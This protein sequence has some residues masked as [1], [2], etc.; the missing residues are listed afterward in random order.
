MVYTLEELKEKVIPI[1]EKH[2]LSKVYLFGSYAR[3]EADKDSDVDL[4]VDQEGGDYFSVYCDYLD[5][6]GE[7]VD[8]LPLSTLLNPNTNIGH[9]VKQNFLKERVL[10]YEG[11]QY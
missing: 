6:F 11:S 2:H 4:V 1:A 7:N 10:L 5:V 8:V 3:N 9:L